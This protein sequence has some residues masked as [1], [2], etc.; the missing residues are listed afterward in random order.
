MTQ[1]TLVANNT[2]NAFLD[3]RKLRDEHASRTEIL[4]KVKKLEM[5]PDDIHVTVEMA[6][7]YYEVGYK[8]INSLVFD[9]RDELNTD[10]LRVLEGEELN[11]FKKFCQIQSRARALTIVPRRALL[12]IGML[13][14]DSEVAK[15]VRSYLLDTEQAVKQEIPTM[16]T[17]GVLVQMNQLIGNMLTNMVQMEERLGQNEKDTADLMQDSVDMRR[18]SIEMKKQFNK[19][20]RSQFNYMAKEISNRQNVKV[21]AVY[22][23]AYKTVGKWNGINI[24]ET[25]KDWGC[26]KI[27]V[28]DR[29][30]L[31]SE[32]VRALNWW[33]TKEIK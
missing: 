15:A 21:K 31:L 23:R 16:T 14:R 10:G 6:A 7:N 13:L 8:T 33:S 5:L 3:D 4:E 9:H 12:R 1:L 27:E 24:F 20:Q 30:D 25:A 22:N 32:G 11:F 2:S 26:R 19:T 18:S 28:L 29:L 17:T